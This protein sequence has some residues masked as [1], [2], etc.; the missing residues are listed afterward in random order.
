MGNSLGAEFNPYTG[1]YEYN[2]NGYQSEVISKDKIKTLGYLPSFIFL[3]SMIFIT[4]ECIPQPIIPIILLWDMANN[5][6]IIIVPMD[7]NSIIH[8]RTNPLIIR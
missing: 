8:Q 1:K 4:V 5:H 6:Q 2:N 3:S 7:N